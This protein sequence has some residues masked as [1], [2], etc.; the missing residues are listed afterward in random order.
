MNVTEQDIREVIYRSCLALDRED[1]DGFLALCSPK[2][3][4]LVTAYSPEI[5][6]QMIWMEQDFEG[7]KALL[8][9]VTQHLRRT[10]SLHRHVSVYEVERAPKDGV[11][12]ALSSFLITHTELDG[13]SRLF[14]VGHYH[15][16]IDVS[17]AAPLL[18]E[19][20]AHLETRDLGIGLHVPI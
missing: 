14:V 7:M 19:R 8:G 3:H 17:G 12:A 10:G 9:M 16:R 4:Y 6:K 11:I 5:R 1:F 13:R 2:L 15:D 18:V 20:R